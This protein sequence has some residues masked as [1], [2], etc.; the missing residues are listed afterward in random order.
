MGGTRHSLTADWRQELHER[1]TRARTVAADAGCDVLLVFGADRH[2][3][4]FRYLTNFEP[5]LGDMWLLLADPPQCF[6]TFQWQ[7]EEARQL[8]GLERWQGQF[9]LVPLVR[10]AVRETGARRLGVAGLERM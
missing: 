10:E 7:I 4:A 2:G 8:S 9:D 5:V 3:Q 1:Q 6:L